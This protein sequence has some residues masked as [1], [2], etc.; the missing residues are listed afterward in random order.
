M[1]STNLYAFY[2]SLRRG[3][4]NYEQFS[5]FLNY[6]FSTWITGFQ[7]YSLGDFPFALFTNNVNDRILIEVFEIQDLETQKE[8]DDLELNYGYHCETIVIDGEPVKIYV[9]K[10]KANYPPVSGGDWVKFFRG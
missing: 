7:L 4:H 2:G 3:L 6:R 10:E 5:R 9:F 8:I 1:A